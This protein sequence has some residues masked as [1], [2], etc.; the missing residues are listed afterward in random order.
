MPSVPLKE[1]KT[2]RVGIQTQSPAWLST[3]TAGVLLGTLLSIFSV[4]L[5]SLIF[6][7]PLAAELPRGIVMALV[8]VSVTALSVSFFSG[9]RGVIAGLQDSPLVVMATSISAITATLTTPDAAMSTIFVLI[10]LTTLLNGVILILLGK[11]KLGI[12]VRYLPYPVIGGFMAGTG[13]MLLLGGIG[14]MVDYNLSAKNLV[15]LFTGSEMELWL[16]GVLFGLLLFI[17]T[18]RIQHS[19]ALPGLLLA[20]A[21][22]FYLLLIASDSNIQNAADAGLLLGD[23][24]LASGW[25]FINPKHFFSARWDILKGSWTIS[26]RFSLLLQSAFC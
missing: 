18:R 13:I 6:V 23:M 20:E 11:F 12:L 5:T 8:T 14:T 25:P 16:P 7:G 26:A 19:L 3:I 1:T 22:L 21:I 9:N 17:G 15:R 2:E 4:S 10:A 24:D